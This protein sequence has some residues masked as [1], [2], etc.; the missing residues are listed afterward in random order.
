[1]SVHVLTARSDLRYDAGSI[2]LHWATAG[3][4]AAL[5]LG[6]QTV[7]AL[8]HA[9]TPLLRSV[10]IVLGL[11]LAV[12]LLVR[13]TWR[14]SGGRRLPGA[15][16]GVLQTAARATHGL[17]YLLTGTAV[18]LGIATA[19][20]RGYVVFG[21]FAFPG[22]DRTLGHVVRGYHALAANGILILALAHAAAALFHHYVIDDGVLRR[23]LPRA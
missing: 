16:D 2:A 20:F 6:G 10:H 17:L 15:D 8:G 11:T 22:T 3:L 14:L 18:A 7:D 5:W 9:W 4:I 1:M 21:L 19:W 13:I 23:M 12:V